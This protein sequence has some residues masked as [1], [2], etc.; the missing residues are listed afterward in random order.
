MRIVNDLVREYAPEL[1]TEAIGTKGKVQMP[2]R[3]LTFLPNHPPII[4]ID[5]FRGNER[6]LEYDESLITGCEL[7]ND[8][9]DDA[10]VQLQIDMRHEEGTFKI[11]SQN[12]ISTRP[13]ILRKEI[14]IPLVDFEENT[15]KPGEY[16]ATAILAD[17]EGK[18]APQTIIYLLPA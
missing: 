5:S 12:I 6:K 16:I 8:T 1:A 4:R 14:D 3:S 10:N 7:V 13:L 9:T 11:Q 17:S 15:D 2:R 18:R